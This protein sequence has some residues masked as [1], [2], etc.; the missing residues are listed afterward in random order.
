MGRAI[1][2]KI[3]SA[4]S[5]ILLALVLCCSCWVDVVQAGSGGA[6]KA[7]A[8]VNPDGDYNAQLANQKIVLDL[9][10]HN[11]SVYWFSK[12]AKTPAKLKRGDYVVF[13]SALNARYIEALLAQVPVERRLPLAEITGWQGYKLS[14]PRVMLDGNKYSSIEFYDWYHGC[15]SAGGF[16][17][18]TFGGSDARPLENCDVVVVAGGG[19]G[20]D[21]AFSQVLRDFQKRGGGFV[22][23][24][25]A[26]LIAKQPPA[27]KPKDRR[28][29]LGINLIEAQTPLVLDGGSES[30]NTKVA[31]EH[32]VMW[33]IPAEFSIRHANGPVMDVTGP[34]CVALAVLKE[35][36]WKSPKKDAAKGKAIW[37]AG[38][39]PGEGRIV[40]FGN[41]PEVQYKRNLYG[42]RGVFDAILWS[43]AG[44]ES[45]IKPGQEKAKASRPAGWFE[46][47]AGKTPVAD[48]QL[49]DAQVKLS[50]AIK[51]SEA[52]TKVHWRGTYKK[53]AKSGLD[54]IQNG[55]DAM[56]LKGGTDKA[57]WFA[58][59]R[60]QLLTELLTALKQWPTPLKWGYGEKMNYMPTELGI[61]F[62]EFARDY[63]NL[64]KSNKGNA[65]SLK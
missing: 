50:Q 27:G 57:D 28:I 41:H 26:C 12:G 8:I 22:G 48:K 32:P 35:A 6:Q 30:V 56:T 36:K 11:V 42:Y 15:L 13:N 17:F 19:G 3:V 18:G 33:H 4:P 52:S 25:N 64:L 14:F 53:L 55:L 24:C 47:A 46:L 40:I 65:L 29:S 37:L 1:V 9:L 49:T 23:S 63:S 39:R 5:L 21:K 2:K 54:R 7:W 60:N 58:K 16:R 62:E 43:A 59:R 44:K 34:S 51:T 20:P 61:K 10:R 45:V 38:Q 31:A